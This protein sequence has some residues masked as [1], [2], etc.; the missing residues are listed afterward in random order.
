MELAKVT[1]YNIQ[2]ISNNLI[3][4]C[5][6][7]PDLFK[8]IQHDPWNCEIFARQSLHDYYGN[9]TLLLNARDLGTPQNNA[10]AELNISILDFND[11]APQ[12]ESPSNNVTIRVPEVSLLETKAQRPV[13]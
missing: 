12:F 10:E 7:Y 2:K 4:T 6:L 13:V 9:Y 3:K 11:H 1:R 5:F 8:L